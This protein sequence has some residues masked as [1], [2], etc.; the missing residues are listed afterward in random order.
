MKHTPKEIIEKNITLMWLK[1]V[2]IGMHVDK[3]HIAID[4]SKYER[5]KSET[6]QQIII[7]EFVI[8]DPIFMSELNDA[9][10]SI[11][12]QIISQLKLNNAFW[13]YD[14]RLIGGKPERAINSLRKKNILLKTGNNK[15][16]LINPFFLRKGDTR[17]VLASTIEL[18]RKSKTID[19]KLI[20]KLEAPSRT[21]I[22]HFFALININLK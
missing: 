22:N 19:I 6:K 1:T 20:K 15:I 10:L 16:H 18:V 17:T 8:I 12:V 21:S 2:R 5:K 4:N 11:V 13:Y 9:E 3:H 7:S 14:Y